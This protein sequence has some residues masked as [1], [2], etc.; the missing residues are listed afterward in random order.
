MPTETLRPNTVGNPTQLTP[1][2]AAANWDCC[3]ETPSDDDTT[4][5]CSSDLDAN[6]YLDLYNLVDT[7]IPAGS[8]INSVTVK[9]NIRSILTAAKAAFRIALRKFGSAVVY[10]AYISHTTSYTVYSQVF[11]GIALSDLNALQ[12]GI[13]ITSRYYGPSDTY[14]HGRCTQ[15]WVEINYTIGGILRRLLVGV[16]L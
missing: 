14:L 2:G 10:S 13:E 11:A 12:A 16:G 7:A 9:V 15:V 8:T 5:V 4:Y 1:F 6:P 3:D